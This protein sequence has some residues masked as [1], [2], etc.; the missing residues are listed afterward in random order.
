MIADT[1]GLRSHT[2]DPIE[3]EGISRA[4]EYARSA[5][6]IVLIMDATS[7]ESYA[8][9]VDDY[10]RDYLQRMGID[11][12]EEILSR[13]TIT[14]LNKIDLCNQKDA[15]PSTDKTLVRVSCTEEIGIDD[16][17]Q[18]LESKLKEL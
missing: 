9:T 2:Q 14:I 3:R 10:K 15:R 13:Q 8:G 5:D 18:I 17:M 7:I 6:I 4:T 1:A 12:N 16:A 11:A